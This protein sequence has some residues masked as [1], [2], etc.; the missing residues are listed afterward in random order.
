MILLTL[1]DRCIEVT[2]SDADQNTAHFGGAS[3]PSTREAA[4]EAESGLRARGIGARL[5]AVASPTIVAASVARSS[6]SKATSRSAHE[7][8]V[9]GIRCCH[10]CQTRRTSCR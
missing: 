8:R 1:A 10:A 5:N 7:L 2:R 3:G 9:R 6:R 4:D